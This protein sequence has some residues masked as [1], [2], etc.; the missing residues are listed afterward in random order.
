MPAPSEILRRGLAAGGRTQVPVPVDFAAPTISVP[1][2]ED[3][4]GRVEAYARLLDFVPG[5][6]RSAIEGLLTSLGKIY[7]GL[8]RQKMEDMDLIFTGQLQ[9][10]IDYRLPPGSSPKGGGYISYLLFG[11]F[12]GAARGA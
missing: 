7:V 2:N 4:L 12:P 10:T 8:I 11:S 5:E 6:V 9:Q 3:L 1:L